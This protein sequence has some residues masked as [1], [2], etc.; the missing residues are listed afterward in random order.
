MMKQIYWKSLCHNGYQF[1]N[2]CITEK[3][4]E[5]SVFTGDESSAGT[6]AN[7]FLNVIGENGDAGERKLHKSETHM[8]K[9]ERNHVSFIATFVMH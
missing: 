7:V 4:Y 1:S 9:F 5:V 6:D 2:N 3:V 8:D